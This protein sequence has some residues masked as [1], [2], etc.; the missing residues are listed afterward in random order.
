MLRTFYNCYTYQLRPQHFECDRCTFKYA[1]RTDWRTQNKFCLAIRPFVQSQH[2]LIDNYLALSLS[3]KFTSQIFLFS[4]KPSKHFPF[5]DNHI[6]L[7]FFV[8]IVAQIIQFWQKQ[9]FFPSPVLHILL[10][11]GVFSRTVSQNYCKYFREIFYQKS[12]LSFTCC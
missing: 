6:T 2:V 11:G 9:L 1:G 3:A 12:D 4:R 7:S 10:Q 5:R 8:R